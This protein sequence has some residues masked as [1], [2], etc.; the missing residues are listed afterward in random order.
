MRRFTLALVLG[1]LVTTVW[2]APAV[3]GPP[4]DL[5]DLADVSPVPDPARRT[6]V[7]ERLD[8]GAW[9]GASGVDA[10]AIA[11]SEQRLAPT[12][13]A[14]ATIRIEPDAPLTA[15]ALVVRASAD[16]TTGYAAT[17]DPHSHR[18]RLFDLDG[19][20]DLAVT[21]AAVSL[22]VDHRLAVRTDGPRLEVVLD[23]VTLLRASD[24]AHRAGHVGLHVWNGRATFRDVGARSV[25][26]SL[27]GWHGGAGW[28]ATSTG[29]SGTAAPG[30]NT[31]LIATD[32]LA[33]ESE[34]S[35]TVQ[36][37][38][39]FAVAT[40]LV[41]TDPDATRGYAVDIDPN[42]GR[43]RLYRVSDNA[44][45][46]VRRTA[47][48]VGRAYG[49][50]LRAV[51]DEISVRW[52]TDFIEPDGRVPVIVAR[53]ASVADGFVGVGA[54]SGS[55]GFSG[56]T[57]RGLVSNV[58]WT[59][60]EGHWRTVI[61]GIAGQG[62]LTSE[63]VGA[64]V[65][66]ALDA[67]LDAGAR[68]VIGVGEEVVRPEVP[69]GRVVRVQL[70]RAA[71]RL[72]LQVDG[73]V[74]RD[75]PA[76]AASGGR[77]RLEVVGGQGRLA[78]LRLDRADQAWAQPF[79]PSYHYSQAASG[80]SDPNGLVFLD[81]EY[82]L[83]HQDAGRWAHAV[84]TDLVHWRPLPIALDQNDFGDAWSGSAVVDE[85]D[86]T[87]LFGGGRGLVAFYT[88]FDTDAPGGNQE[89]RAAT[90]VDR[91]RTWQLVDGVIVPNPGGPDGDWDFRDP[92]VRW[93]AA[94]GRW[95]MVVSGGDHLR[96]YGSTDLLHWDHLS[97]FG[98][99]SWL[100]GGVMECPD[101]MW[102]AAPGQPGGGRWVLWWSTGAVRETHG[103][104]ARYVTGT[105]D[106]SF[107]PDTPAEV[108]LRADEGRDY[109]AAVSFAGLAGR[110]V[111]IG[112]MSNWDYAFGEPTGRWRGQ[113]SLP[114]EV[115][116]TDVP[117]V[118]LRLTQRPVAEVSAL[119]GPA[120]TLSDTWVAPGQP[121][122]LANW[123][124]TAHRFTAEIA[125]PDADGASEFTL[126]VRTGAGQ[127]TKLLWRAS[128]ASL[129]LDR[130]MAGE[131]SFT[132]WFADPVEGTAQA[133]W[134]VERVGA[135]RRVRITG[136]V[137]TASVE[138]FSADGTVAMTAQ[139]FP[140]AAS[141]GLT[142]DVTGGSARLVRMEVAPVSATVPRSGV[143]VAEPE[144]PG[145]D[146]SELGAFDVVGGGVW[147]PSGAGLS[148]TFDRDSTALGRSVYADV[149]VGA[150]VRFGTPPW[151]GQLTRRDRADLGVS[152]AGS[153]VVRADAALR[154]GYLVNFDPNL[155][156][157]RVMKLEGGRVDEETGVL[158]QASVLL[159]PG[160]SHRVEV[161]ARGDRLTAWVDGREVLTMTDA[162]YGSGRVGVNA[163]GGRAAWQDITVR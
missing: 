41:R 26:S 134:P 42:G 87:G 120:T 144:F 6:G 107:H 75:E 61:D 98:Y 77:V 91:G 59:P 102:V 23:G 66:L 148:T 62:A 149:R 55:V 50:T 129:R 161:E 15:A 36:V 63:D 85:H 137:D 47:I 128:D 135:E 162:A 121:N 14:V 69:T 111:M 32:E 151:P 101:L 126:G 130:T 71:G 81:G 56:V 158:A 133:A 147:G 89:I 24:T 106:G 154:S 113:L 44:T 97:N 140:D 94:G 64:D 31:R 19:G 28:R 16:G 10:N 33:S 152:G 29:L 110:V 96:F 48:E 114:R 150:T 17:V 131:A 8:D 90:S 116:L 72:E 155:H 103:S 82:H 108:V 105:F 95:V 163:F 80:T 73:R 143:S 76:V 39:R 38:D 34:A 122:P 84:S 53:D 7:W 12:A 52:Q 160:V 25:H 156:A 18:V 117:G 88:S 68:L 146:R 9:R 123:S 40:L 145:L 78:Q 21:D 109:Y 45:L 104:A 124:G 65:E 58:D 138:V 142:F 99:G 118:G 51:G 46:G 112:W 49:V 37:R 127:A 159:A 93:D 1:C 136:W 30:T 4:G 20:R 153:V 141:D 3:A 119:L 100:D 79:R 11:I 125:V 22:G 2:T 157:V 5:F 92:K 86:V 115:G 13:Q 132:R 67:T 54:W 74:V 70:R 139:V 27:A 35:A 43:L 83:F 60:T 57:L